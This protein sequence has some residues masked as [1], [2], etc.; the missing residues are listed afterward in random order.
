M[1]R[2]K[3]EQQW[4]VVDEYFERQLRAGDPALKA[5]LKASDAAGLPS[6]SVSPLQGKLLMVLAMACG[7]NKI[8]EIGTLGGY[9]TIFLARALTPGGKVTTIEFERLHYETATSNIA[10]AGLADRVDVRLGSAIEVLPKLKAEGA[11]PFDLIFIDAEKRLYT[12][13]LAAALPLTRPGTLI[14]A[15]NVV[16]D[17]EVADSE[18]TDVSVKGIQRFVKAAAKESRLVATAVQT[19]GVKGYDGWVV[20]VVR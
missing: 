9:S 8:L 13:F 16:R 7:A 20:A 6:I 1:A 18:S 11:G 3:P 4:T 12:E 14:I 17:G 2:R 5:T 15:D 10:K 19:V